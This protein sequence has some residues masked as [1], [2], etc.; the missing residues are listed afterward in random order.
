MQNVSLR[1]RSTG[2]EF[3]PTGSDSGHIARDVLA[4]LRPAQEQI[5]RD[6]QRIEERLSEMIVAQR[7]ALG[8]QGEAFVT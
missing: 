8:S 5:V 7:E 4:L 3:N 6:Q 2:L 1:A